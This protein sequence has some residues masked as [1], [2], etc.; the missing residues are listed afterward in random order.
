MPKKFYKHKTL[1]DEQVS[2][3]QFFPRL[4]ELFDVKYIKHDLNLAGL[5]DPAIYELALK[6]GRIILTK[7]VRDFRPLLREDSP[8]II[9]IPENWSL[10]RIDSK[11]IALLTRHG[12]NYFR[13]RYHP[14]AAEEPTRQAA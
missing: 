4:N 10:S 11:L 14:L 13:G 9:S 6:Q 1:L 2:P 8:G 3:R 7:N 5:P 12:P